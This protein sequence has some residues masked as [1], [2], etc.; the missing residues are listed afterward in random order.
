MMDGLH[1]RSMPVPDYQSLMRPALAYL[2]DGETRR[3]VPDITDALTDTFK[4]TQSDIEQLLP[5]GLQ[6]TLVNRAHWAVTYMSKAGLVERP[7]RGQGS[8]HCK[9]P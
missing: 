5:S 8:H 1:N 6:T 9:R 2:S 7:V 3:V 4:L